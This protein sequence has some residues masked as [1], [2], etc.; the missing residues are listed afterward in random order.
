MHLCITA[1]RHELIKHAPLYYSTTTWTNKTCTY[2]LQ[3]HD[4]N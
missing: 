3:H 1:P 4:M 2:V